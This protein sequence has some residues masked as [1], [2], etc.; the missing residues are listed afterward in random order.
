[1][2]DS[3]QQPPYPSSGPEMPFL[4]LIAGLTAWPLLKYMA[5]YIVCRAN[6]VFFE[7]LKFDARRRYD[8]YFGVQ[9]FGA[10]FKVAAL[11]ACSAALFT[12]SPKTD[13]VGLVRPL[14]TAEQWCWGCR[15]VIFTQELQHLS[16]GNPELI[17]HHILSIADMTTILAFHFPRRQMYIAWAGLFSELAIHAAHPR[18]IHGK[19]SPRLGWWVTVTK[20]VLMVTF[21]LP[22]CFVAL[23]WTLQG[24]T[25]ALG[26]VL[27]VGSLDR[28][29]CL[30]AASSK[31][32]VWDLVSQPAALVVAEKW[33]VSLVGIVMGFGFV[34]MELSTLLMYEGLTAHR[35]SSEGELRNIARRNKGQKF[36]Q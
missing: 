26:L 19:L 9:I 5:E 8:V 33:R 29:L 34:C 18:K 30:H 7:A 15:A 2:R 32:I 31:L 17:I 12:T 24:G 6:P 27:T 35:L 16:S 23:V 4:P 36:Q 21:R 11:T 1:M 28:I 10:L 13:I 20:V 25:R 22:G 14:N 3:P